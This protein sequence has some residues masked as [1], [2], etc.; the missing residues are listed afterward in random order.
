MRLVLLVVALLSAA[1]PAAGQV[2]D[3]GTFAAD[4]TAEGWALNGGS[5][6]RTHILF[7]RFARPFA[8]RPA[9]LLSLSGIDG[10]AGSDGNVRVAVDAEN[11]TREGFVLTITT[12]ADSRVTGVSGQWLAAA[13]GPP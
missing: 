6:R 12:W 1:A 9:V 13:E 2:L 3:A 7:I 8:V 11:V 5:G 4:L 10:G